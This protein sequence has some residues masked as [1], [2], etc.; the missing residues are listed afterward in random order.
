[1]SI[2]T[3]APVK[4]R[5]AR[6]VCENKEFAAFARRIVRAF[7]RRIATGDVEALPELIA[8][9]RDIDAVMGQ[10]VSALKDQGYSWAE[11]AART[12]T[13]RQG[14]QQRWAKYCNA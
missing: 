10:A 13:T 7:G 3:V 9:Q 8:L 2:I 1:M 4:P 14:A 12:G 5:R 11:I 6:R